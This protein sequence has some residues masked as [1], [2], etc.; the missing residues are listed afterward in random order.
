MDDTTILGTDNIALPVLRPELQFHEGPREPNGAPTFTLYDPL[1]RTYDKLTWFAAQVLTRMRRPMTIAQM[2]GELAQ[3]TTLRI[4]KAQVLSLC[5]AAV[6]SGLTTQ[7][8]VKP[9]D[10]LMSEKQRKHKITPA[11][12]FQKLLFFRVP[13]LKPE[14]FLQ[15]TL[16]VYRLLSSRAALLVY[17]LLSLYGLSMVLQQ[18]DGFLGTFPYFFNWQGALWFSVA[19]VLVKTV[20]EF[21]HAYAAAAYGARVPVIWVAFM[22]F[23]PLAYCD[24]TDAWKLK[25]RKQRLIISGAGM[26]SE[27]ALAGVALC[28]WALSPPGVLQSIFFVLSSTSLLSTILVNSNPGMRYDGYYLLMDLWGIDNLQPRA[29]A[30]TRWAYRVWLLGMDVPCPEPRA[31][32]KRLL[33]M[34]GYSIYCWNYR[35]FLYLGIAVVIYFS[36][37]K[38]VGAALF[39]M[40]VGL[41][42]AMP[43]LKEVRALAKERNKMRINFRLLCT[44]CLLSALIL[45]LALPLPRRFAIPAVLASESVQQLYAPHAGR[46]VNAQG[47]RELPVNAGQQLITV[48][49]SE[50]E[51]RIKLLQVE[52][53][54]L[55]TE[56]E[57]Y[58]LDE[59][60]RPLL[61]QRK[62]EI[63]AAEANLA[64]L[65]RQQERLTLHAEESGLLFSWQEN[66]ERGV[67]VPDNLILGKIANLDKLLV[68]AFI[69][70]EHVGDLRP[71]DTVSFMLNAAPS[72]IPGAVRSISPVRVETINHLALTSAAAGALPVLQE[73]EGRLRML[74]SRYSVII[75]LE[76]AP[77]VY[78]LGQSG[79]VWLRSA[80]H[81]YIGAWLG[82]AY[83][84]LVR[85]S[86]F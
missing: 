8:L 13:I 71:G 77:Q 31:S 62:E 48:D 3:Q 51:F 52:R 49:S 25:N 2:M 35:F 9:I 36:V 69:D 75:E 21:A 86:G 4:T 67:Y 63:A 60:L 27:V 64:G 74:E 76:H 66:I 70:E 54:I 28:G 45:W 58:H 38:A 40:E 72:K 46:V 34:I 18:F 39:V 22:L 83:A 1:N 78:R 44:L 79:Q 82:R 59:A 80:P 33:G 26:L 81:S 61:P 43:V 17:T 7:T 41:F 32:R 57:L 30:V 16:G 12:L 42:I 19:L 11:R 29:F 68:Y 5:D 20:H 24:V 37:A 53:D 85:E 55:M 14:G 15:R 56:Q 73:E 50:L 65:L 23:W 10:A 47:R 6:R 84:V